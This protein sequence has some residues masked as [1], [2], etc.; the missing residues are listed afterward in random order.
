M[1]EAICEESGNSQT[2]ADRR[3]TRQHSQRL[4]AV[5]QH[6]KHN[7]K[8]ARSAVEVAIKENKWWPFDRVDGKLLERIHKQ[9]LK[10]ETEDALL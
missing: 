1:Q 5:R 6:G 9:N 4:Q 2:T 8:A 7:S 10:L 3:K